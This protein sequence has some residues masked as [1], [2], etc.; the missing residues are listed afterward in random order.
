M[1]A[2]YAFKSTNPKVL[3]VKTQLKDF[4]NR[5]SLGHVSAHNG[6]FESVDILVKNA[7]NFLIVDYSLPSPH[8][9][10]QS[11]MHSK[12][13]KQRHNHWDYSNKGRYTYDMVPGVSL[14]LPPF[15]PSVFAFLTEHCPF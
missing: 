1:Q 14:E 12:L 3:E 15:T 9:H 6:I 11:I 2:I 4:I 8:S 10:V 5:L 7:T 13:L